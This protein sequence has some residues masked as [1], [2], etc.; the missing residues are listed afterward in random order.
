MQSLSWADYSKLSRCWQVA[1]T[2]MDGHEA[3][4]S[5]S[6]FCGTDSGMN[7]DMVPSLLRHH[8]QDLV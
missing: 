3:L 2:A 7:L 1:E 5:L 4:P 8:D 6:L